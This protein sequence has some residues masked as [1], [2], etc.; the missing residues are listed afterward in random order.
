MPSPADLAAALNLHPLVAEV[1][2][3]R[4]CHDEESARAFLDFTRYTPAPATL[5]PDMDRAVARLQAA[6]VGGEHI[7]IWGDF[8]VDGQ[9]ATS[10]LLLGLRRLGARVDFTIPDRATHSHGLNRDGVQQAAADGVRV[11]LT[12]DCGI[13]EFDDIDHAI[14]QGLDV[15][16]SDHHDLVHTDD[17]RVV[18]PAALAVVNPKRL[19]PN[20]VLSQLPG[21]GVAYKVIEALAQ[22]IAP[23]LRPDD[24]LD[25]VALGIVTDV[26][27][28]R[29]DT[30]YLLQA[31]LHE[32]RRAPRPGVR[33]LLKTANI[34]ANSIDADSVAYQLG[35]RL[36]AAGRLAH[37]ALSVELLTTT[38]EARATEIAGQIEQLNAERRALQKTIESSASEM[39]ERD[40]NIVLQPA[41]VL[42]APDWPASVIGIVASSLS[43]RY[44]KPAIMISVRPGEIG[45]ASARSVESVDIHAAIAAT[46][47]LA[48]GGGGHPMA[49]GFGIH[50][51][52]VP[53][54]TAAVGLAVA[55]QL[56]AGQPGP[57]EEIAGMERFHVPWRDATLPLAEQLEHLAPFGAGNPRPLLHSEGLRLVRAEPLG[58]DGKHQALFLTDGADT[59]WRA[60]WWRGG[61]R[62][63]PGPEIPLALDFTLRRDVYRDKVRAQIE[64]VN[65]H[66]LAA[67]ADRT[68]AAEATSAN[69]AGFRIIDLRSALD[70]DAA[71]ARLQA[72][73]GEDNIALWQTGAPVFEPRTVLALW[74]APA[75]PDELRALL[76]QIRPGVVALLLTPKNSGDS[77]EAVTPQV[78]GM[79]KVSQKRGDSIDD[80]AVLARMAAR[81]NQRVAA[82]R[83][84]LGAQ[85]GDITA[86][87]TLDYV[88]E[89]TRAYRKYMAEAPAAEVLRVGYQ[90]PKAAS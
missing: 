42:H 63:V 19:P 44:H 81:I 21:V 40:P 9:T 38:D 4:G 41:I 71:L 10:V 68:E 67:G 48:V 90:A 83:A 2:W 27:Q 12:C 28:Q 15:I 6:I 70:R 57:G 14:Q 75:G 85:K 84:A 32:M 58:K 26:A 59:T 24:L 73:F 72:E 30:R 18:L 78:L 1:L 25:L 89:E 60:A 8:D 64:V 7:R 74:D 53:A 55:E 61:H 39:I 31:G 37:A 69:V 79:L 87:A 62:S 43:E 3:Q 35:P 77:A 36:N 16:V 51:D 34:E 66:V 45:R 20:H 11:L 49:A 82:V 50:F 47:D 76:Q 23:E 52:N 86:R 17:G 65:L 5:L 80:P 56:A 13:A 46:G 22:A 33:A 29:G 54:F 88:L